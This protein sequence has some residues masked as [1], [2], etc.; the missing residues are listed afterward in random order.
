M[1]G[2]E[3]CVG[4]ESHD[5]VSMIDHAGRPGVGSPSE[6]AP[7]S[8]RLAVL[9]QPGQSCNRRGIITDPLVVKLN[10]AAQ[11]PLTWSFN[12]IVSGV[13]EA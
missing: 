4:I 11:G 3:S 7:R 13:N 2:L 12:F 10:G 9:S 8:Y 6:T 1:V 5:I